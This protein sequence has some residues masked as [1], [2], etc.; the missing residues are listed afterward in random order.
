MKKLSFFILCVSLLTGS[1]SILAQAPAD[2]T[3]YYAFDKK[4]S[5]PGGNDARI[6]FLA[7]HIRYPMEAK[8]NHV[9]GKVYASFIVEPNGTVTHIKILPHI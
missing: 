3:I 2:T 4:P 1:V 5:F 9:T 8:D 7:Q 6:T